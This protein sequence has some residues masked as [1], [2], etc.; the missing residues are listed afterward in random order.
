MT[1]KHNLNAI[2]ALAY[3]DLMKFLRDRPRLISTF[4][5]PVIFI[6]TLGGSLQANLGQSSG[7][8]FLT[9]IFTGVFA[10]TMFQS[11]TMGIISILDDREN[12]FS[13]EIFVSPVS[14]YSIVFGKILGESLVALA[15]GIGIV[16]LG[17]LIGVPLA[18]P[19]LIMLGVVAILLCLF[20]GSFGLI[21]ISNFQTRR[22]ADMMFNFVMLPQFFLAGV[23]APIKVLPIYLDVLSRLSPMRY[24]VDLARG[25]Y[26]LGQ[27]E[28]ADVV[29][30]A[31]LFNLLI[32]GALF[33]VFI[34]A[35]TILFVRN[36]RNR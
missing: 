16:A 20:G 1:M 11:A 12:D 34:V 14:R 23:F 4:I 7:Y 17:L 33:I 5:F 27:A 29:L 10:Q 30:A 19:Q 15:Q 2:S 24:A 25:T 35:G 22:T 21:V 26:Y 18:V 3:R 9:F 31:P 13:Q 32:M 6:I 36:E 28:Y 8:N